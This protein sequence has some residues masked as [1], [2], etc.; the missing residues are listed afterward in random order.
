MD[1]SF[2]AIFKLPDID[3]NNRI[4]ISTQFDDFKKSASNTARPKL[5]RLRAEWC[6]TR[7]TSNWAQN[8]HDDLL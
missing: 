3:L 1:S 2:Y 4:S 5:W 8:V 6:L 7:Q